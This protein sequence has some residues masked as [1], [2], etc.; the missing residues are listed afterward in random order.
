MPDLSIIA[1]DPGTHDTGVFIF[2][3]GQ[4][5]HHARLRGGRSKGS[6]Q[7]LYDRIAQIIRDL[8]EETRNVGLDHEV[9]L[10]FENPVYMADSQKGL[11]RPIN[12]LYMLV[13]ALIYWGK[14]R[15]DR[16]VGYDVG[17]VKEG[18]AGYRSASKDQVYQALR[19]D[20]LL[21]GLQDLEKLS[22]HEWD[23]LSVGMYHLAQLRIQG[24]TID[25]R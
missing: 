1:I 25:D 15:C 3:N 13:G 2:T 12:E 7:H 10:V 5:V 21:S 11:A 8:G 19:H 20:P 18:I 4:P 14:V 9:H 24:A 6:V 16:V 17:D 22:D 23:A